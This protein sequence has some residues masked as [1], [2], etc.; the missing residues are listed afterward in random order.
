MLSGLV[1]QMSWRRQFVRRCGLSV[2][3]SHAQLRLCRC[4]LVGCFGRVLPFWMA[5]AFTLY[6][7][8]LP[9]CFLVV[10][11]ALCC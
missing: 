6:P 10:L 5:L 2:V 11:V 1:L 9:P 4:G 7:G 3:G 8:G